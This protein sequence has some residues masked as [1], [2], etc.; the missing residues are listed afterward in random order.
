MILGA[1]L[2]P[3]VLEVGSQAYALLWQRGAQL[4]LMLTFVIVVAGFIAIPVGLLVGAAFL[5]GRLL[6]KGGLAP[7][8][9]ALPFLFA[10]GAIVGAYPADWLRTAIFTR[11]QTRGLELAQAVAAFEGDHQRPP[12]SLEE[13]VPTYIAS[14]PSTALGAYPEYLYLTKPGRLENLH[15]NP[16][17]LLVVVPWLLNDELLVYL[18][19]RNYED[20]N[21][22]GSVDVLDTWARLSLR[23]P[24]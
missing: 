24:H 16:W 3:A 23:M 8:S 20:L 14:V 13:L 10:G 18:P 5:G 15:G 2:L 11:W 7:L 19:K 22:Q 17:A 6:R 21:I 12:E 4:A 1:F 9:V